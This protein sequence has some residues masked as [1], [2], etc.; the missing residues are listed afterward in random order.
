MADLIPIAVVFVAI[1]VLLY[2][3]IDVLLDAYAD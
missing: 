3:V 2:V 1:A